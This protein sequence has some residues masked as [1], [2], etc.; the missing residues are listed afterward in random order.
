MNYGTRDLVYIGVFAGCWGA[1][2]V[3]VGAVFHALNVPFGGVILTGAGTALA[4][5]GRLYVPRR[6]SILFIALV[7]ALLKMLSLGGII[8][9]PMVAIMMEG[10]LAEL[11]V[12][13]VGLGRG[14]FAAAGAVAC[15]WPLVHTTLSL[16][17][18]GRADLLESYLAV[19][20][21]GARALGVPA[22]WGLGVLALLVVLHAVIGV[23]AGSLA[24][25]VGQGLRRRGR[26]WE[27]GTTGA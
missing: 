4:L 8:L 2:E 17:V 6:G 9:S 15:L 5:V 21:R 20:H 19:I 3:T 1:I 13:G 11:V 12:S 24:W 16:W 7:T 27:G 22:A 14:A 25:K 18:V 10:L 23:A 26:S